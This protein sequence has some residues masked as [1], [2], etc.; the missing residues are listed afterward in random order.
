MHKPV[1]GLVFGPTKAEAVLAASGKRLRIETGNGGRPGGVYSRERNE[2]VGRES[3]NSEEARTTNSTEPLEHMVDDTAIVLNE[4]L[5]DG[6]A[7]GE[8]Q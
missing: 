2:Q 4:S 3:S 8:R 6:G 5:A 1:R 7:G